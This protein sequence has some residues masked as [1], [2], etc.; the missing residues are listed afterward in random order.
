MRPSSVVIS[1]PEELFLLN[2]FSAFLTTSPPESSLFLV[3][4][5]P[6]AKLF[7]TQ[8]FHFELLCYRQDFGLFDA[9]VAG[10]VGSAAA[11]LHF[12]PVAPEP[13][14]HSKRH[15][16]PR[17]A[18]VARLL[19]LK[20]HKFKVSLETLRGNS[21]LEDLGGRDFTVNA[22]YFDL[23]CKSLLAFGSCLADFRDRVIRSLR[24]PRETFEGQPNVLFRFVEFVTRFGLQATPSLLAHLGLV[25]ASPDGLPSA[26]RG[27]RNSLHSSAK[28]FFGKHYLSAMLALLADLGLAGLFR[29]DFTDPLLFA[30]VFRWAVRL[31][32]QLE[33]VFLRDL[34][35]LA[36]A[37][38]PG[39]GLPKVF[40]TKT[41]LFLV[42]FAFFPADPRFA[43]DFLKRFLYNF[44]PVPG[45]CVRLLGRLH[46]LLLQPRREGG[47]GEGLVQQAV[48]CIRQSNFDKSKW[49]FLLIFRAWLEAEGCQG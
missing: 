38:Y 47:G 45:E 7:G 8:S 40:H 24:S 34:P 27:S 42:A 1:E 5:W 15:K 29:L 48:C 6:R 28:K 9:M 4:D 25:A 44:K 20:G 2:A 49:G 17:E 12:H 21:L 14:R 30:R 37:E 36:R 23:R 18:V 46:A 31:L 32:Q 35:A 16:R 11:R 33:E 26:L 19:S 39:Q 43:A 13:P 22:L 10:V 3:G 41:R